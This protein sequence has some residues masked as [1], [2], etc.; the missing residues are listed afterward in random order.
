MS[1]ERGACSGVGLSP[2]G[3]NISARASAAIVERLTHLEKRHVG[4]SPFSYK[5][6]HGVCAEHRAG[7][8]MNTEDAGPVKITIGDV[9]P[10]P[11]KAWGIESDEFLANFVPSAPPLLDSLEL[12]CFRTAGAALRLARLDR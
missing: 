2:F 1:P 12:E 4:E 5:V 3:R 11:R 10:L 8:L 7:L 9:D 6:A